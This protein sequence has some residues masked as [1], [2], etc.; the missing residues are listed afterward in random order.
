MSAAKQGG[1]AA[2]LDRDIYSWRSCD[3]H[4][5]AT[6]QSPVAIEFA[7]A[8]AKHDVLALYAEVERLRAAIAAT[9]GTTTKG[10]TP[11]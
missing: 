4:A 2:L 8:D 7:F 10:E 5:M 6:Q 1:P 11:S 3:P 9:Q